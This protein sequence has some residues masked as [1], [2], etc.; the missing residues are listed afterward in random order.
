MTSQSPGRTA[1]AKAAGSLLCLGLFIFL[2]LLAVSPELHQ[3]FHP[4]ANQPDH[5]CGVTLM[6]HGQ[7]D[8]APG[9]LTVVL[10]PLF[11]FEIPS[12][13]LAAPVTVDHH[14]SPG[15]APPASTL[16]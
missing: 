7:V 9:A 13:P 5:Q 15:R 6:A 16:G 1:T 3:Y 11:A 12:L 8:A 2:E 10:S 4:D 14:F